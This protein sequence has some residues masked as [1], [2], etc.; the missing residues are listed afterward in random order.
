M[1]EQLTPASGP[2]VQHPATGPGP[3]DQR[4]GHRRTWIIVG[5]VFAV[6]VVSIAGLLI[7]NSSSNEGTY[8]A[9]GVTNACDLVD[10]TVLEQ[11]TVPRGETTH[12]ESGAAPITML[13]CAAENGYSDRSR[14]ASIDMTATVDDAPSVGIQPREV[15]L[16]DS[17]GEPGAERGEVPGIGEQAEYIWSPGSESH[18]SFMDSYQ[19]AV[20][21]LN[22]RDDNL[23]L[24]V[25][26]QV[27]GDRDSK[28]DLSAVVHDQAR[29]V[30]ERLRK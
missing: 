14:M 6:L 3:V 7:F 25:T 8:S 12:I 5:A 23:K 30:M 9:E 4:R 16:P 15:P 22:V 18:G 26:I 19:A 1:S 2:G 10:V 20:Y 21:Q 13:Q 24:S 29:L 17:V 11:W 27:I 28:S